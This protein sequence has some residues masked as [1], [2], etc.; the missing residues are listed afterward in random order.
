[1]QTEAVFYV[2][3]FTYSAWPEEVKIL[4][5]PIRNIGSVI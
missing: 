4:C 5:M 2:E 1:M 3:A